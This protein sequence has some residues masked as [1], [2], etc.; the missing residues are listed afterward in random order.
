MAKNK[1]RTTTSSERSDLVKVCAFWGM[2]ISAIVFVLSS[3]LQYCGLGQIASIL[4]FIAQI[5]LA[6]A[7]AIPAYGYVRGRSKG[8]KI[9]YW[10]ALVIYVVGCVLGLVSV[11]IA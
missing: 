5:A 1:T 10:I 2:A 4:S 3:I 6:V 9:F 8:W 11:Y 7:V